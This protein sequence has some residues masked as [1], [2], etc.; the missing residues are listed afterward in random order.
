MSGHTGTVRVVLADDHPIVLLAV[1][2]QF[3]KLPG[4]IITAT[5]NSGAELI[6]VLD[7]EK[8]D[9]VITDLVMQ[10]DEEVELDG[11]RLVSKLRRSHPDIPLVVLTMMASGGMF[12]EL[13]K[14]GVA[15]IVSKE[16]PASEL[17]RISVRALST[18]E[19]ILSSK[20]QLRLARE[21]STT[22]D[23]AREQP[24]SPRELEVV[25][26]FAQGLSVTEI[27]RTLNRSVPTVATQK[28]SAMRKLHVEN[29]VDLVKYAARTGLA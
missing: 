27:A 10:G 5:V 24:L 6:R 28:R 3:A 13:C 19:T 25:R 14:L 7:K 23:L 8:A 26:L 20:I 11:L 17:A 21:G 1:S 15:A 18:K 2:D 29:H 9:L 22:K 16:E 4:F 12:H